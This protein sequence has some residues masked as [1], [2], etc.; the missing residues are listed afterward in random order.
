MKDSFATGVSGVRHFGSGEVAEIFNLEP[1][2][3]HRILGRYEL[4]SSG[5]LG[6][7]RGSRRWFTTEDI[8]RIATALF[9]IEDG[10]GSKMVSSIVQTLEDE[11]F[12][13]THNERG[14]FSEM[15]VLLKRTS[16]G[17]QAAAFRLNTPPEIRLSGPIYYA[18]A[19]NQITQM[20]DRRIKEVDEKRR[21]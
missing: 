7:G 20:I 15:G 19:L 2:R 4:T 21:T 14:E 16:K 8:Y 9:L 5:Q 3:L 1:W 13:G 12:Y 18:L 11:D 17:R 10:F 6:R